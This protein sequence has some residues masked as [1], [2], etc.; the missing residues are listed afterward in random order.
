M[1]T[2]KTIEIYCNEVAKTCTM[3]GTESSSGF[4]VIR[5]SNILFYGKI[6]KGGF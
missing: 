4:L 6:L 3:T 5:E 1:S 2:V